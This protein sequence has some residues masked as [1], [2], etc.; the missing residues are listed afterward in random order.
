MNVIRKCSLS[1]CCGLLFSSSAVVFPFCFILLALRCGCH[2]DSLATDVLT[3]S[4][5]ATAN[6]DRK[7]MAF[8]PG[9]SPCGCW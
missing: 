7:A 2:V 9:S 8:F 1:F 6:W 3:Y 4:N 5:F